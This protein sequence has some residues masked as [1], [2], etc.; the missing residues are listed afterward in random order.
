MTH[1]PVIAPARQTQ[2]A[3]IIKVRARQG[4]LDP[5]G[6]SSKIGCVVPRTAPGLKP[7][8]AGYLLSKYEVGEVGAASLSRAFRSHRSPRS[9]PSTFTVRSPPRSRASGSMALRIDSRRPANAA[10]SS[11]MRPYSA[12]VSTAGSGSS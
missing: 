1:D 10:L 5:A 2:A 7:F 3:F 12:S 4:R 9:G 6:G 8:F 11:A